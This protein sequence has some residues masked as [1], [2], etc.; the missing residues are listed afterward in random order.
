MSKSEM[1][2]R[3]Y[4]G[5]LPDGTAE[6][7]IKRSLRRYGSLESVWVHGKGTYAFATFADRRDAEDAVRDAPR[8]NGRRVRMELAR[9]ERRAAGAGP[10][11]DRCYQCDRV[12]HYAYEC[13]ERGGGGGGGGGGRGGGG[14]GGGGRRRSRSFSRSR[15]DSRGRSYSRSRSRSRSPRRRDGHR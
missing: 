9:N 2:R 7:D 14:G 12:G 4:V 5:D 6:S 15:S 11:N 10:R 1:G 3:V 8:V 13:P